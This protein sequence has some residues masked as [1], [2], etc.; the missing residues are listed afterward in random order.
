MMVVETMCQK[1]SLKVPNAH[2]SIRSR[3][4]NSGRRSPSPVSLVCFNI[5]LNVCA[6]VC[7]VPLTGEVMAPEAIVGQEEVIG[8]SVIL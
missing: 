1:T 4:R 6:C 3:P 8:G 5:T 2:L 7:V